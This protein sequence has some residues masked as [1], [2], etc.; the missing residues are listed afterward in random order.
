[1]PN[2]I[3]HGWD[4]DFKFYIVTLSPCDGAS[5]YTYIKGRLNVGV[6]V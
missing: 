5:I 2:P 6:N 3:N 4:R 1:M